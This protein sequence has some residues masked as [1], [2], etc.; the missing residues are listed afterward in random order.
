MRR[1]FGLIQVI[2]FMVIL[3]GILSI[4]MKYASITV[5][6]TEDLYIK[7]QAELFMQSSIE[8]ALL[9]ISSTDT[10]IDNIIVISDDKRFESNITITNSYLNGMIDMNIIVETNNTHPKNSRP[11][12]LKKRSLQRL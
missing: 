9:G 8:L 11:V 4:S 10:K 7:E 3:S 5:K 1:G 12:K 2:F 6:Q